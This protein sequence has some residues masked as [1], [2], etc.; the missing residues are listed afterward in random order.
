VDRLTELL[1]RR[2]VIL[3]DG[4]MGTMLHLAKL[5]D[6]APERWNVE[7]PEIVSSIHRAYIEAG[8]DFISTNTFGGTRKRLALDGLADRV[9]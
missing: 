5:T 2:K 4:A 6:G 3:G 7:R 9:A 8:S 1:V